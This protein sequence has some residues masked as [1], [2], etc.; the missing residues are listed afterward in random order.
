MGIS[1]FEFFHDEIQEEEKINRIMFKLEMAEAFNA[2]Y[3]G[4][5]HDDRGQNYYNYKAW[6]EENLK[7]IYPDLLKDRAKKFWNSLATKSRKLN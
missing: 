3:I 4:A 6:R 1:Q 7:Q 2:A 5:Q